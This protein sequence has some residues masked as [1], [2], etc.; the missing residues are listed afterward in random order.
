MDVV[1]LT[2]PDGATV[3]IDAARSPPCAPPC[4]ANMHGTV[5]A[6]LILGKHKRQARARE[7]SRSR[8]AAIRATGGVDLAPRAAA[9]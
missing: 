3:K 4:R 9:G 8:T 7:M 2:R 1:K 6:V 5:K